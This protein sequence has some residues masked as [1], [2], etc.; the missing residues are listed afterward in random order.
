MSLPMTYSRRKRM[1]Q[2]DGQ[3]QIF[4]N[5]VF[6][7]KLLQQLFHIINDIHTLL[8]DSS[9]NMYGV[10]TKYLV[11]ELG[12]PS[13]GHGHNPAGDFHIWWMSETRYDVEEL[14]LRIDCLELVG[15]VGQGWVGKY[16]GI[17]ERRPSEFWRLIGTMNARMTEDG[18]GF[19]FAE[20]QMVEVTSEHTHQH[21][22]LPVLGLLRSDR[23][24]TANEEFRD[25]LMEFRNGNYP[26]CIA[27]CGNALESTLKIIAKAKGWTDVKPTDRAGQ[28]IEA[29]MRHQLIPAAMQDQFS[30]LKQVL[31]GVATIRN[32]NGGHGQGAEPKPV[33]RSLAS[34][35]LNQTAAAILFLAESAGLS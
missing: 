33:P 1:R 27:D 9:S 8:Y 18:F 23:W 26:D 35:Q 30:G 20:G 32:N 31:G 24:N 29:A 4:R 17:V 13:L 22:I 34:Y 19:Q 5:D 10:L 2:Q 15:Q 11:Q 7:Q 6:G 12:R 3:A 25:A 14:D 16:R 21:A 28:L